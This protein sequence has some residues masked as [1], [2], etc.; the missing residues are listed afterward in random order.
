MAGTYTNLL[1]HII[2]STKNREK[3]IHE[4]LRTELHKYIGGII[5]GEGGVLI[6]IGGMPEHL[7]LTAKFKP[8]ISV[9]DMLQKTKGNSSKWVN[10]RPDRRTRFGWQDG[11]GAFSVSESQLAKANEYIRQQEE[12]HRHKTYK[13]EFI[14]FLERH[15]VEYDERYIW[16]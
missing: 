2:Y 1:Y 15:G 12:H 13:E 5:R 11:Y 10:E 14:E 4:P 9:S 8:S 3:L 16:D 7:H 6:E